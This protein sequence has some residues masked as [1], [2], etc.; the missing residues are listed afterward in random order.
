MQSAAPSAPLLNGR[1]ALDGI[2][3]ETNASLMPLLELTPTQEPEQCVIMIYK[4]AQLERMHQ[5]LK[6]QHALYVLLDHPVTT[7]QSHVTH[8]RLENT[9]LETV[10]PALAAP[11]APTAQPLAP[12]R[13]QHAIAVEITTPLHTG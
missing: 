6:I 4:Y 3:M 1:A 7:D 5:D 9:T 13:M 10:D 2:P 12:R 8:V 11:Q